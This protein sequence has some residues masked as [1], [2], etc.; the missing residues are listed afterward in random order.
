[1]LFRRHFEGD[2]LLEMEGNVGF[3]PLVHGPIPLILGVVAGTR[4]S[5]I[6]HRQWRGV[7][8]SI[9]LEHGIR[10]APTTV[11]GNQPVEVEN[12]GFYPL[13]HGFTCLIKANPN[14]IA[15]VTSTGYREAVDVP[16]VILHEPNIKTSCVVRFMLY[17]NF[18]SGIV[19]GRI[20]VAGAISPRTADI[21][22]CGNR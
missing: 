19:N 9:P 2:R 4:A 20:G 22:V 18:D 17:A 5:G 8:N 3:H 12:V 11:R 14:E 6:N 15:E 13:V 7:L 16:G 10:V 1:M 21:H